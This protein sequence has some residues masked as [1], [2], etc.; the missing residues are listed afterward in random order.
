MGSFDSFHMNEYESKSRNIKF[1][2]HLFLTLF[3]WIVIILHLL[4]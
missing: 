3:N 4:C 1:D 2:I